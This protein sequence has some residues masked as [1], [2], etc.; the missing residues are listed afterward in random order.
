MR[1]W[2][3]V[4]G[5]EAEPE[6]GTTLSVQDRSV[7]AALAALYVGAAGGAVAG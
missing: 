3:L 5:G 2:R 4:L 7:D 6:T 1:R